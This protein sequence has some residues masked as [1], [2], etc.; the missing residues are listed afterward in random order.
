MTFARWRQVFRRRGSDLRTL[1]KRALAGDR[2]DLCTQRSANI[3]GRPL[4]SD[5]DR[6]RKQQR[7]DQHGGEESTGESHG[8]IL[9]FRAIRG[10]APS[11]MQSFEVKPCRVDDCGSHADLALRCSA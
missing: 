4:V 5:N 10:S 9:V 11:D 6:N 7:R 2:C 3:P 1:A 8:S